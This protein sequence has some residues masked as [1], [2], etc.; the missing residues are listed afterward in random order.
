MLRYFEAL[1]HILKGFKNVKHFLVWSACCHNCPL[2]FISFWFTSSKQL[3]L[4]VITQSKI[5]NFPH[6][7][8]VQKKPDPNKFLRESEFLKP[9][10]IFRVR[11]FL[12]LLGKISCSFH[13][14]TRV[15]HAKLIDEAAD[16]WKCS[17]IRENLILAK[18][19]WRN[20]RWKRENLHCCA[21][22]VVD[23]DSRAAS[24]G[25]TILPLPL[26]SSPQQRSVLWASAL[27]R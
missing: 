20:M 22:V 6:S 5:E 16:T 18:T 3:D 17:R 8:W 10:E 23:S 9:L 24:K 25:N 21:T 4:F 14:R 12:V 2:F 26:S 13:F 15:E 11:G 1:W 19:P 7:L 27:E